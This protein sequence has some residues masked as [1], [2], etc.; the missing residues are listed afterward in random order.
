MT[1]QQCKHFN[2][3]NAPIC[4]FDEHYIECIY[5]KDE[6]ICYYLKEGVK[7]NGIVKI[8]GAIGEHAS[9]KVQDCIKLIQSPHRPPN[10]GKLNKK[11]RLS[12]TTKSRLRI[13]TN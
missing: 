3:C 12:M 10:F 8:R 5:L 6:P 13:D 1:S 11:L 9:N 4:P 2:R 7:Q